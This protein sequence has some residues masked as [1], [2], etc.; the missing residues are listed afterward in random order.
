MTLHDY[1][2]EYDYYDNLV[3]ACQSLDKTCIVASFNYE[4]DMQ[5]AKKKLMFE[6]ADYQVLTEEAESNFFARIGKAIEKVI[7]AIGDFCQKIVDRLF[8]KSQKKHDEDVM[9]ELRKNFG[10]NP[11]IDRELLDGIRDGKYTL[12]D[13]AQFADDYDKLMKLIEKQKEDAPTLKNKINKFCDKI[14]ESPAMKITLTIGGILTAVTAVG[15]GILKV[16]KLI[17]DSKDVGYNIQSHADKLAGDERIRARVK[18][19]SSPRRDGR[20]TTESVSERMKEWQRKP[21]ELKHP[22]EM[23]PASFAQYVNMWNQAFFALS[24]RTQ[25]AANERKAIIKLF[26]RIN[27]KY[28]I[29]LKPSGFAYQ[30]GSDAVPSDSELAAAAR[31]AAN[32]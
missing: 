27:H 17:G 5:T 9:A 10:K 7:Q 19:E 13:V 2:H 22:E 8:G 14:N 28:G 32:S 30:K 1:I 29:Y 6:N 12:H 26:E 23:T 20:V 15:A 18:A 24:N 31:A 11:D 21:Y 25:M 3:E 4:R 16:T